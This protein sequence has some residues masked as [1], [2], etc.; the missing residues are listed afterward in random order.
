MIVRDIKNY[1]TNVYASLNVGIIRK[2]KNIA[3]RYY[4][5]WK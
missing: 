4:D 1:Q 2:K 3:R 5:L